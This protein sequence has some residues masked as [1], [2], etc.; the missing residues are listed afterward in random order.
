MGEVKP[1]P[2]AI[3]NFLNILPAGGILNAFIP[4]KGLPEGSK[5][6]QDLMAEEVKSANDPTIFDSVKDF[7]KEKTGFGPKD[8]GASLAASPTG[9]GQMRVPDTRTFDMFGNVLK[10]G[11]Q[12]FPFSLTP[13]QEEN[14]MKAIQRDADRKLLSGQQGLGTINQEVTNNA[15][16]MAPNVQLADASAFNFLKGITDKAKPQINQF[17]Q[18]K[19]NKNLEFESDYR[20]DPFNPGEMMPY[21]GLKYGFTV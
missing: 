4:R 9:D 2:S 3:D 15:L 8:S 19:F 6:Y 17:L 18:D 5:Q 10:G 13:L 20:Q 7:V 12:D 21:I 1:V 14:Y 11:Q 16:N